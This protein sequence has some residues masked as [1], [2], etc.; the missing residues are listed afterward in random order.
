MFY[1]DD[2]NCQCRPNPEKKQISFIRFLNAVP[3]EPNISFDIYINRKLVIR[4][5][6]YED[7]TEEQL[8]ELKGPK[9]DTG[10]AN[11]LTIGTVESGD[12]TSVSITG[13]A[14]NQVLNFIL[15]KGNK[16]DKRRY[17]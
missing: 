2:N 16:G 17:W 7:F 1:P 10:P 14:P 11:T 9:G 4:H 5:L 3:N 13:N 15:E 12:S 8:E 6:K